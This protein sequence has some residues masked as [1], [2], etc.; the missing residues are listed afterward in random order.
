MKFLIITV[1]AL[2]TIE[3]LEQTAEAWSLRGGRRG[4]AVAACSR[5]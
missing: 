4:L 3:L 5:G 2:A 1:D